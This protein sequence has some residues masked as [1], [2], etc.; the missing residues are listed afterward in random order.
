MGLIVHWVHHV[1]R[2]GGGTVVSE[3]AVGKRVSV[4]FQVLDFIN[5]YYTH[6]DKY[7]T[8][9]DKLIFQCRYVLGNWSLLHRCEIVKQ[10][11]NQPSISSTT[12][13]AWFNSSYTG[14]VNSKRDIAVQ[15]LKMFL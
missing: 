3:V 11:Y 13:R 4:L 15:F 1:V 8:H 9:V 10:S 2:C 14:I 12:S 7:K 6:V 5:F